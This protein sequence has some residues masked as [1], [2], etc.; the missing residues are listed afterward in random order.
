MVQRKKLSGHQAWEPYG[1]QTA[2]VWSKWGENGRDGDGYEY[3]YVLTGPQCPAGYQGP[4]APST[5]SSDPYQDEYY[6]APWTDDPTGVTEGKN[7]EWV[8][9]RKKQNGAW[10]SYSTPALWAQWVPAGTQGANGGRY[11]MMYKNVEY[12][13]P[14]PTPVTLTS[15]EWESTTA[16]SVQ[17]NNPNW[18]RIRC[19]YS[20]SSTSYIYVSTSGVT[21]S[22]SI[23]SST[24]AGT[25]SNITAS[26]QDKTTTNSLTYTVTAAQQNN[27]FL[28]AT[29][30]ES[31][32]LSDLNQYVASR[33][34]S[35]TVPATFNGEFTAWIYPQ[36]WGRPTSAISSLSHD[37][38]IAS[39]NYGELGVPLGYDGMW[40]NVGTECTYTL[41]WPS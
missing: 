5:P 32:T 18:P 40:V 26:Y 14:G 31:F 11:I 36:S 24:A 3:I 35:I 16:T 41:T 15:I 33:P 28:G 37:N 23:T 6:S 38:E 19:R 1:P 25:Y 27:Y 34:S 21:T 30:K 12:V 2:A 29:T 7:K 17:G 39:F 20:D 13:A 9:T 4:G 10:G 8:S 22:R